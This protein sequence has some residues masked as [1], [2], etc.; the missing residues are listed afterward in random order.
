MLDPTE[1]A[2]YAAEL[3][4]ARTIFA[5]YIASIVHIS[6]QSFAHQDTDAE[7]RE[8]PGKYGAPHGAIVLAFVDG[9][10]VGCAA[11]RPLPTLGTDVC[12][13]KRMYVR[14]SSRGSGIGA[15]LCEAIFTAARRIGYRR[16]CLDSDPRLDAAI[17]LYRR[18]G[19]E[20]VARFN[21]DPDDSTVYMGRNLDTI[22]GA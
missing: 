1:G 19:F 7:L 13:L 20:D 21:D 18:M 8:L 22:G 15:A 6:G 11:V 9:K 4:T 3:E 2:S 10:C 5:E 17:R 12:E 14:G 16:I